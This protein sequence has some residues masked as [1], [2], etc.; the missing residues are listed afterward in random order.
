MSIHHS[1]LVIREP[2]TAMEM[3]S[4]FKLRYR[5]YLESTCATLVNQNEIGMEVDAY[6]LKAIHF[7]LFQEGRFGSYPLAYLRVIQNEYSHHAPLVTQVI[8]QTEGLE[9]PTPI[10]EDCPLPMLANCAY[11]DEIRERLDQYK[12]GNEETKMAEAG[13]LVCMPEVRANGF[14]PFFVDVCLAATIYKYNVDVLTLACHPRHTA[15]YMRYGFKLEINGKKNDYQGL[16]ASIVALKRD[17]IRRQKLETIKQLANVIQ[18]KG[19][20]YLPSTSLDVVKTNRQIA[21]RA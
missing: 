21:I 1:T 12:N 5:G 6:D 19:V 4:L 17:G 10:K 15:F 9:V 3:I 2:R 8:E 11:V 16:E 7:G 13:R 18:Q 20:V 14:V